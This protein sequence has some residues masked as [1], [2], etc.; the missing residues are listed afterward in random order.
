[1]KRSFL[2][3]LLGWAMATSTG[4]APGP[5]SVLYIFDSNNQPADL[6]PLYRNGDSTL[7]FG[8][9]QGVAL[10]EAIPILSA[11]DGDY[12]LVRAIDPELLVSALADVPHVYLDPQTLVLKTVAETAQRIGRR[13]WGLTRLNSLAKP[14]EIA[15]EYYPPA[16]TVADTNIANLV[17]S[18]TAQTSRQL[19]ADIS[20]IPTRYSFAQACRQA[21]QVI[22]NKFDSLGLDASYHSFNYSGTLMRNVIGEK[23]GEAHPESIIIVCAHLDCTSESPEQVAPGA[24]DNASGCAVVLEAARVLTQFPTDLTVRFMT[25]SGEEQGLVG[26]DSYASFVRSQGQAI[27]AVLNVDMVGYSGLYARDMHIFCDPTS[28]SLGALGSSTI[29]S[30]T[31]LDTVTHYESYPRYGSD[32]YPFATRGYPA[33]FFIDAWDGF[34]WYPYYHTTADTVGYLNMTQQSA[35]GRAVAAMAATLARPHFGPGYLAGDA[36]GS[37][38]VNGIDV[39]FMVNYFKGLG[40]S[41]SPLLRADSNGDCVANG[42]DVVF[43]VNYFKGGPPPIVG[44]CD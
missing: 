4:Q 1:M 29:T 38:D 10:I 14:V 26:S 27:V 37:G 21:E 19:I 39:V 11:F 12:Y 24:E 25:F 23:L 40:P 3:L 28:F 35:I 8:S 32:H 9:D 41:P 15:P 34:D 20:T 17:S 22:F 2:L 6:N 44:Q 13:G 42:L 18:I 31:T 36:N 5:P 33:I 43:L 7:A 16:I 30:Y